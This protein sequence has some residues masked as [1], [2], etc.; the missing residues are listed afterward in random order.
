MIPQPSKQL[1]ESKLSEYADDA[2]SGQILLLYVIRKDNK[3]VE[4]RLGMSIEV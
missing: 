4:R 3:I 1:I 2:V